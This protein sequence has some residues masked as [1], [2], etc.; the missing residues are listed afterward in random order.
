[1]GSNVLKYVLS[2]R[3]ICILSAPICMHAD[4]LLVGLQ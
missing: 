3:F 2:Y 1:M 4:R